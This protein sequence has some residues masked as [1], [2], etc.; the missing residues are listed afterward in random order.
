M[1]TTVAELYANAGLRFE[2]PVQWSQPIENERPGVY[3][4]SVSSKPEE[5]LGLQPVPQFALERVASWIERVPTIELD[6]ARISAADVIAQRLAEF[7][8]PD[9]S[10]LYIGMTT[11]P[12]RERVCEYYCTPLGARAPHSGGHWLKTLSN[13]SELFL[14]HAACDAPRAR[15]GRLLGQ[16]VKN[17][18]RETRSC[19][20]D[21][22]HPLPFA[23][24]EYPQGTRKA[25]GIGRATR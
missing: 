21:S 8:L 11:R 20:R 16:F 6:G 19:L 9:E 13:L 22:M 3:V 17:V 18:S 12:L 5:H 23:N 10:I 2:G 4:V 1:P 25:H 15:E 14:Y 7:W 24:L